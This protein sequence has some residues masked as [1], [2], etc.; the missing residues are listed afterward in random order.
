MS[1]I[2]FILITERTESE[3]MLENHVAEDAIIRVLDQLEDK[4]S[5]DE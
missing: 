3:S 5:T 2:A 4:I 1:A